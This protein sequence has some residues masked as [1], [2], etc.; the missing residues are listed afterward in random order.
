MWN[1]RPNFRT[2]RKKV[3]IV[4]AVIA[5]ATAAAAAAAVAAVADVGQKGRSIADD[6]RN[7]HRKHKHT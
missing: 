7:V 5:V 6:H 4:D 2:P 1:Y 3:A